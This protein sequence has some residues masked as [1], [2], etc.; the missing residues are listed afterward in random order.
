MADSSLG[1]RTNEIRGADRH[2]WDQST[3]RGICVRA[4][5]VL[6]VRLVLVVLGLGLIFT[7]GRALNG[8][9]GRNIA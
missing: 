5:V 7:K 9:S 3:I 2:Q 4:L 8:S 1:V 6:G